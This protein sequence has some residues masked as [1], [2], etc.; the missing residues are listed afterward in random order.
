MDV[1]VG[2]SDP[3]DGRG[4]VRRSVVLAHRV[5]MAALIIP[6]VFDFENVPKID[7][8]RTEKLNLLTK[9]FGVEV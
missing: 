8:F 2:N 4:E 1:V 7:L 6:K 5:G 9:F 3:T